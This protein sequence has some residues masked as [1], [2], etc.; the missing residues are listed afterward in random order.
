MK[1]FKLII[2]FLGFF[3]SSVITG[4]SQ[5]RI[6]SLNPGLSIE[7]SIV[8][9]L[10]GAYSVVFIDDQGQTQQFNVKFSNGKITSIAIDGEPLPQKEWKD[11]KDLIIEFIGYLSPAKQKIYKYQN[12][13]EFESKLH[14]WMV[15]LEKELNNSDLI[16][17]IEQVLNE[18]NKELDLFLVER[19]LYSKD[20]AGHAR[21]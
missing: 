9:D 17:E 7:D 11:N 13:Y 10:D 1:I 14:D 3:G 8:K 19:K 16:R 15:N 21:L 2:L 5:T 18:L 4:Y 20:Q 6:D 12:V